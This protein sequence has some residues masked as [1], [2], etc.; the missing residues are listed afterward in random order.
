MVT[1]WHSESA[2]SLS[3]SPS[4]TPNIASWTILRRAFFIKSFLRKDSTLLRYGSMR[5]SLLINPFFSASFKES[6]LTALFPRKVSIFLVVSGGAEPPKEAL[7]FIP[8][9]WGGLWEAV[10]T[11]PPARPLS[12]MAEDM[13]WVGRSSE[14]S[15][16]KRL[17]PANTSATSWANSL[18]R[19]RAS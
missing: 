16:T 14:E 15:M 9:N 1:I 4:P 18:E 6:F 11:T 19:K 17:L 5:S 7:I 3:I 12:P 8:L 13:H 2:R 10:T